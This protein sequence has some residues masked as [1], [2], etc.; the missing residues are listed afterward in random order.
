MCTESG[1]VLSLKYYLTLGGGIE[2]ADQ[3]NHGAFACA[4]GPDHTEDFGVI[5]I[6]IQII[7]S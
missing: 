5:D 4:I 6:E 1:N 2:T 7:D 3:I